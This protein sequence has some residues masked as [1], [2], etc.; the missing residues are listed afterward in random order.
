MAKKENDRT[1]VWWKYY[2][3]GSGGL[4]KQGAKPQ[5]IGFCVT[6]TSHKQQ[7]AAVKL[8]ELWGLG[9][10][11]HDEGGYYQHIEDDYQ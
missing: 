3:V 7:A 8:C 10:D 9:R 6:D 4:T 5:F 11:F 1:Q 2:V